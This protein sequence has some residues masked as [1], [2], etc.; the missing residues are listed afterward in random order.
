MSEV[1]K[2]I[3]CKHCGK[4]IDSDSA[5][6]MHCGGAIQENGEESFFKIVD[7]LAGKLLLATIRHTKKLINSLKYF[8]YEFKRSWERI[9]KRRLTIPDSIT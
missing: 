9:I 4:L 7:V 2:H 8:Y 5:F 1:S 3:Y 6:C